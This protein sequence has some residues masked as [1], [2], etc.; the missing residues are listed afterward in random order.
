[1]KVQAPGAG[2]QKATFIVFDVDFNDASGRKYTGRA[3]TTGN[4]LS[5]KEGDEVPVLYLPAQPERFALYDSELGI[6][7]GVAKR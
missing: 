6:V 5:C 2:G 1:M 4:K 3:T 7:P